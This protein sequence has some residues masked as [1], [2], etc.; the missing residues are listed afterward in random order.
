MNVGDGQPFNIKWADHRIKRAE[1]QGL[2]RAA[3]VN[4]LERPLSMSVGRIR[5]KGTILVRSNEPQ[6]PAGDEGA[7]PCGSG[8]T[9]SG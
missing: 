7:I 6:I 4:M 1:R 9:S 5:G 3:F 2:D 8:D